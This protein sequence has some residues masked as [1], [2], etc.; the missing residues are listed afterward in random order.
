MSEV[1]S[2]P[3]FP[4]YFSEFSP[5]PPEPPR[6]RKP[7][8]VVAMALGWVLV[9]ASTAGAVVAFGRTDTKS[10]D[11]S[12]FAAAPS[13]SV[14]AS[15][16]SSSSPS[17]SPSSSSSAPTT[18]ATTTIAPKPTS[19]VTGKVGSGGASH[20][21]DLRYFL[22]PVPADGSVIGDQDGKT[23]TKSDVAALYG[24]S[25]DVLKFLGEVNFKDGAIRD[26][27]TGDAAYH[28]QVTLM[29]FDSQYDA[30]LWFGGDQPDSKWTSFPIP[31]YSG[32]KGWS[33]P[34]DS[35]G[36]GHLRGLFYKGDTM[37]EIIVSGTDPVD[38]QVLVDAMK[39]Q[40][41]RLTTGA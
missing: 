4:P 8:V 1:Q 28:V 35:A 23:L 33:I 41:A 16:T 36:L 39:K 30:S 2:F 10:A 24:G 12:L 20:T 15:G 27:Q 22:L 14:S 31:G 18:V 34:A 9:A 17:P 37:F 38:H 40:I 32:A 3:E 7:L 13:V 26:Y 19:T 21:G 6:K 11:A 25:S 5:P 29:R